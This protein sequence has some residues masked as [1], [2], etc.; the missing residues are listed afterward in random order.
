MIEGALAVWLNTF[1]IAVITFFI[2]NLGV[3]LAVSVL[4]QRFLG[5]EVQP[6]KAILWLLVV[7]PWCASLLVSAYFL[8][9]FSSPDPFTW[10]QAYAH[11]HH[12][13][14]YAVFSWHSIT[15]LLAILGIGYVLIRKVALLLKHKNELSVLS[16]FAR[17]IDDKVYE[18][19][20]PQACAFTSGF[21]TKRCYIT[22]GMLEATTAQEQAIILGHEK[23]HAKSN[24]PL[25]KW[26]FSILAAFF[27]PSLAARLKLHMTLAMEQAADNAVLSEHI[28]STLVA[29]TLVKVA[30]LNAGTVPLV[31]NELVANF[32]ADVLEQRVYFLLG[33]L[34]LKPVNKLLTLV[35]II[36]IIGI[37][38]SGIDSI[39]HLMETVFSH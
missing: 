20:L 38:L 9:K 34:N 17:E 2:A 27:I 39:H 19:E 13:D 7:T 8:Y 25:K 12:M 23:A 31:N 16:A 6:R 26:L 35:F 29:G 24:D 30:R 36:L 28:S 14:V 4:G 3:S 11:W 33:Q 37:S 15:L 1:A 32:G 18:I 5:M 10:N 22:T 21:W